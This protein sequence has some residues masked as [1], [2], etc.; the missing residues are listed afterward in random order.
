MYMQTTFQL[1]T[2]IE[3]AIDRYRADGKD[4]LVSSSFQTQSIPLLHILSTIDPDIP[5]A[6]LD[7]GYHF[8]ETLAFRDQVAELLDLKLINVQGH[9][10]RG[11]KGLYVVSNDSCCALNKVEPIHAVLK[12][13]DVWISGVRSDQ[14]DVRSG[15]TP[16]M[17][18]PSNTERYHPML[19]WTFED[20]NR[21]RL[22]LD[23]PAHPLEALGYRSIGCAP[24]TKEPMIKTISSNDHDRSGRWEGS[25]KTECG[26]HLDKA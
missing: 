19:S 25:T 23:L 3:R 6:F 9:E 12:D 24:C 4:L 26:L 1:L 8:P 11:G 18:G 5:V 13:F 14:T 20:I 17:P 7:T 15:F 2:D 16:T 21:Y 22:E 10:E